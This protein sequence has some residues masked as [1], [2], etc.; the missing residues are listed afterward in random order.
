[1]DRPA[2]PYLGTS[3]KRGCCLFAGRSYDSIRQWQCLGARL[4]G[5][6]PGIGSSLVVMAWAALGKRAALRC[7]II[8]LDLSDNVGTNWDRGNI[9]DCSIR[10]FVVKP[11][12]SARR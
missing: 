3:F 5:S 1:M 12:R 10:A 8:V 7:K 6:N 11:V 4:S 9:D 2:G